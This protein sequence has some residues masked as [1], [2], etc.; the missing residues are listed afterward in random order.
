VVD[1]QGYWWWMREYLI[2]NKGRR[3][4]LISF[5]RVQGGLFTGVKWQNSPS[6]HILLNDVDSITMENFEIWVDAYQQNRLHQ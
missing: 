1:G 2:L 6:Y 5:L 4:H 3:P